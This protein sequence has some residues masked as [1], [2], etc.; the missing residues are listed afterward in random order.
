MTSQKAAGI[1]LTYLT[2]GVKGL[3]VLLVTPLLL[4]LLGQQEY[5]LYQM[6][7]SVTS[8]LGLLNFGF[9]SAYVREYSRQLVQGDAEELSRLN[10]MF[11]LIFTGLSLL[12]LLLGG[13]LIVQARL[14]FGNGLTPEELEKV[15]RLLGILVLNLALTLQGSLFDCHITARERFG[16][17]KL[18]RLLQALLNPVLT[19]LLLQ[20]GHGVEAVAW[21]SLF[22]TAVVSLANGAYCRRKLRM[23]LSFQALPLSRLGQLW[24]FAFFLFLNQVMDQINWNV[25]KFLLGRMCGTESVALYGVAAQVNSLYIQLSTAVSAVF[26]PGVNRMAARRGDN[27]DLSRL[28]ARVG[29]VQLMILG[30][31]LSGFVLFGREFLILWAGR[32]YGSAYEIVLLLMIPMTIP[33]IQNLGIEIQRARNRHRTRSLVCFVLAVGNLLLSIRLIPGSGPLGAAAGT[34]AALLAGN[35][36]FMNWYYQHR[37][38][39]DMVHFWKAVFP[40]LP[41]IG[42]VFLAGMLVKGVITVSSWRGFA[43]GVTGYAACYGLMLWRFA[44]NGGEKKWLRQ[45]QGKK[46]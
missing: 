16:F 46:E 17:Q 33:L 25:D 41:V 12:C 23:G 3:S 7:L 39:L 14:V 5:G 29:R 10:G 8:Y 13:F 38:K 4:R 40:L 27:A 9:G 15:R 6:V 11:F 32:E 45:F 31:I 22:L 34:A 18:L 30:L 20:A 36:V 43:L 28:M 37:L 2:E 21:V 19:V 26:L 1:L 24:G 35:V 44:M 42:A